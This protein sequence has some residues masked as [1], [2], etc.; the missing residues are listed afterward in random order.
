[1]TGNISDIDYISG[2]A[3]DREGGVTIF[4]HN[5]TEIVASCIEFDLDN[6]TFE[7]S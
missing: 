6:N 7:T 4:L 1:M 5:G 3:D 2:S